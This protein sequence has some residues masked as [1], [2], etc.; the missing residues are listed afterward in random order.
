MEGLF[1]HGRNMRKHP[2]TSSMTRPVRDSAAQSFLFNRSKTSPAQSIRGARKSQGL[3]PLGGGLLRFQHR[4][5]HYAFTLLQ[6]DDLLVDVACDQRA[7]GHDPRLAE[8]D[9]R[10]R[11]PGLSVHSKKTL[12]PSL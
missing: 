6:L 8:D 11:F 10:I 7:V 1:P 5:E 9:E 2:S 4:A 3:Q 12:A